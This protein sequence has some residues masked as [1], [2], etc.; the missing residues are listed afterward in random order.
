VIK[1]LVLV[2]N[3]RRRNGIRGFIDAY[4]ANTGKAEMALLYGARAGQRQ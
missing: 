3:F 2:S 4:D 1:D